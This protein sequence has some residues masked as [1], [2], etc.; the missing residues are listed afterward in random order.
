MPFSPLALNEE[1]LVDLL[2]EGA[3]R[4]GLDYKRECDLN[5]TA[6]RV[7]LA[8]DL[9]AMQ[10]HGGYIVVGA[11]DHGTPTGLV[12][13]A[14]ARLFDQATVHAKLGKYLADGFDLRST[15][16]TV[17]GNHFGLLCVLAHPDGW[18]PFKI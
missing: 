13:A 9:G 11:D 7:E 8:K 18:A 5:D 15:E 6:H 4:A 1:T 17:D 12:T 2:N 10:I 16:L 3:E 14:H